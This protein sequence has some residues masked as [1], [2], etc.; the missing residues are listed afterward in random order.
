MERATVLRS[1][2]LA[3]WHIAAGQRDIARQRALITRIASVGHD[4]TVAER[5]LRTLEESQRLHFAD[6]N[7]L[8]RALGL[9]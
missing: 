2:K 6:R 5:L 7:R 8:R 1:L 4:T 3:E 9:A